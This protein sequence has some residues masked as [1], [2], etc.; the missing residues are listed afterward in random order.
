MSEVII[1]DGV[2]TVF[3]ATCPLDDFVTGYYTVSGEARSVLIGHFDDAHS[4]D[5]LSQSTATV[6]A[7]KSVLA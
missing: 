2:V 5:S 1:R 7:L 3:Q 4:A 6:S